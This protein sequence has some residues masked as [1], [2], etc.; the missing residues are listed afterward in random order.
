MGSVNRNVD[1][2]EQE[3]DSS[4]VVLVPVGEH[5]G[6]NLVTVFLNERE[7]WDYNI[8]AGLVLFREAHSSVNDGDLVPGPHSHHVHAELAYP[9]KRYYLNSL[10][11]H[12]FLKPLQRK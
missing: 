2:F 8:D 11:S 1:L 5:D 6:Q 4:D 7:V 10:F 3:W 12:T 9:A